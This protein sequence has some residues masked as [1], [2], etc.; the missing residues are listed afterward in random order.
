MACIAAARLDPHLAARQIKLV[1][2]HNNIGERN[3]EKPHRFR[4]R[5]AALVHIGF[6]L[7]QNRAI[8]PERNL[9][10]LAVE[11][12]FPWRRTKGARHRIHRHEADVMPIAGV[13]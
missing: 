1:V 6:G 8:R 2:E 3:F 5:L 7:Q 12:A 9:G 11:F 10:N 13:T 4:H